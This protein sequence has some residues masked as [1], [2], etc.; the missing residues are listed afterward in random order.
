MNLEKLKQQ[1]IIDEGIK[2]RIYFDTKG[3]PTMGIGHLITKNDPE[4]YQVERLMRKEIGKATISLK[5]VEELYEKDMAICLKNCHKVFPDFEEMVDELKQIIANM[6]FNMGLGRPKSDPDPCGFLSMEK[7]IDAVKKR[8]YEEAAKE[9]KDSLWCKQ[10]KGRGARLAQEMKALGF[11]YFTNP[12]E[13]ENVVKEKNL[14][15]V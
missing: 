11:C 12:T 1:L 15:F 13:C 3:K 7:F 6:M 9:M 2:L 4:N 8:N 14:Q 10:V 5:R